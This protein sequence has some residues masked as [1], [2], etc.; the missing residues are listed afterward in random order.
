[1]WEPPFGEPGECP[2]IV[3]VSFTTNQFLIGG[4]F[5]TTWFRLRGRAQEATATRRAADTPRMRAPLMMA[6]SPPI[7]SL[8]WL[9]LTVQWISR[10]GTLKQRATTE[11]GATAVAFLTGTPAIA[12]D[13]TVAAQSASLHQNAH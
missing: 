10:T 13:G 3:C 12:T 9:P 2:R 6:P 7:P 11:C 1:M 4:A 8:A 5:S